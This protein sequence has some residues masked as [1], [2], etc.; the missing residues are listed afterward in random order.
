MFCSSPPPPYNLLAKTDPFPLPFLENH[1]IPPK[2]I[3]FKKIDLR[4]P[5]W[6]VRP[7]RP[8]YLSPKKPFVVH[9]NVNDIVRFA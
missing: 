3:L 8:G 7:E 4:H 5:Y 6:S 2:F 1:V 9:K